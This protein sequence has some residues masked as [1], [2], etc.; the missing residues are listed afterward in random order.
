MIADAIEKV[1]ITTADWNQVRHDMAHDDA[2]VAC[3]QGPRRI[4]EFARAKRKRLSPRHPAVGNPSLA[5][6]R[7]DQVFKPLAEE[8]HDRYR[9]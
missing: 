3:A 9:Q 5:D 1:P 4:D 6:E 7:E 2:R 8:C